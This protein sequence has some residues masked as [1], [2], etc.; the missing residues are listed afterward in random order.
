MLIERQ[1]SLRALRKL[2][3]RAV[4]GRG[5]IAL[6]RGEAGIGKTT[7]LNAARE[8][9]ND[10]VRF[11]WGSCNALFTPQPLGPL[12]DMAAGFSDDTRELLENRVGTSALHPKLVDELGSASYPTVL[13]IEDVHWADNATLDL[14]KYLGRRISL[15]PAVIVLSF[16]NDEVDEKHP[17]TA[18]LNSFPRA[19]THSIDLKPLSPDGVEKLCGASGFKAEGARF[20]EVTGGN[21]FFVNELIASGGRPDESIPASIKEA[22]NTRLSHLSPVER[23]FLETLSVLPSSIPTEILQ[24]LFGDEG[25][26]FAMAA[27][28]RKL[29]L[30]DDGSILRFRHELARLATMARL[31]PTRQREINARLLS[32]LIEADDFEPPLDQ[33]VH[34]AAGALD[35]KRV[36]EYAPRAAERA[37]AVGA[38]QEA[39]AHLQTALHFV[40]E[41]EPELAAEIYERWAYEAGLSLCIDDEVIDARRHAITLW[42]ALGRNEKVAENLRWLSRLHWYRAESAEANRFADEAVRLLEDSPPS[43]ERAM[44]YS[45][46]SQ[47]HMLN[48]NMQEAVEWGEKALAL[49]EELDEPEIRA[50]AL[51]NVGTAEAFR[52]SASGVD[53]LHESL[54]IARENGYHEHA[55]RVYTNLSEYAV[56]FKQFD[57]AE[58]ITSEGIAFDTQNDLDSWTHYLVGRQ[59]Q[60]RCEE[61]R[62]RD[63]ETISRGVLALDRLTLLMKL[64]ARLVL[65]RVLVLIGAK[66]AEE[67]LSKVVEDAIAT[68]EPQH[69]VPAHLTRVLHGWLSE[70]PRMLKESLYELISIGEN[71]MHAWHR[72]ELAV[73]G[74]R[75]EIDVPV[76][77]SE[78]APEPHALELRGERI[79]SAAAW[80]KLGACPSAALALARGTK[81]DEM[82]AALELSRELGAKALEARIYRTAEQIGLAQDLPKRRRGP[83]HVARNHPLGLTNKEQLVLS[84]LVE[85][86]SNSEIATALSRSQRTV[87]NHVSSILKKMAVD[88]RMEAMLRVQNEPWLI[89]A[90]AAASN[91]R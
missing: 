52:G 87:E 57:L 19:C 72:A 28:G 33:L 29:L 90:E 4:A 36:L 54:A 22:V 75:F 86:L 77:F 38:H 89:E 31:P 7:L 62:L 48:D 39:A 9:M 2:L 12:H 47:L 71:N 3:E 69:I 49:A 37:A 80:N 41:A 15:I 44:A 53:R 20:Y 1:G 45:L 66:D 64:P 46:R 58:R 8:R 16:R 91:D 30:Q 70:Q 6:V 40:D 42:R 84:L 51:C 18:I 17:L 61:G 14:L 81:L 21:P 60:L 35:G 73:W 23:E 25:E 83:Y 79:A 88:N 78:S 10:D 63:A 56:E 13:V 59:A 76:A 27:I 32:A 43:A 68:E 65:A 24:P 74:Q 34:H 11:L 26:L 50:H 82:S 5:S 67:T 85:G 55:A